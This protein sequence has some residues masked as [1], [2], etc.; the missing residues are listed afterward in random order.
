MSDNNHTI[1]V[2][3]LLVPVKGSHAEISTPHVVLF[4]DPGT[5][6]LYAMSLSKNGKPTELKYYATLESL[7]N[8]E[9]IK[10][11]FK[12]PDYMSKPEFYVSKK[13]LEKRDKKF[14]VIQPILNEL[15]SFLVSNNY[16]KG[17]IGKCLLIAEEQEIKAKRTQIY[18]WLY[19]Y[20]RAGCKINGFLRKPGTGKGTDKNY[21][22]KTGPK[23]GDGKKPNGRMRDEKDNKHIRAILNKHV[24]CSAP[25]SIPWAFQEYK[26][27]YASYPIYDSFT[28]DFEGYEPW[29]EEERITIFQFKTYAREHMA[30]KAEE[31]RESQGKTDE[32][33]KNRKGL[34]GTIENYYGQAPGKDYQIDETPLNIELVDEFDPKREKRLGRPTCY[35]V[36]DMFSRAWV[37]LLLTF[38]KS[39]V[40]TAREVLFI[41]FR[42]KQKFCD[43]IGVK[44]NEPW[45]FEK[46]CRNIIVDNLEFQAELARSFSKD[47]QIDVIFNTEGNSQQKGLVERRHLSLEDFLYSRAPGVG[48][49]EIASYVK[50]NLRKNALLNIRELYQILIDFIT[51]YNNYYPLKNMPLSE[52]M[53]K[54]GVKNT[55]LSKWNWGLINRAGS[56]R[57]VDDHELYLELLEAGQVTV[58][59][60]HLLLPGKYIRVNLNRKGS[61][62]LKYLC[63]WVYKNGYQESKKDGRGLP[64][65]PCK[66]MRYSM[67][68]I[69]IVTPDGLQEAT[70]H[71]EDEAYKHHSAEFIQYDKN[72]QTIEN[73]DQLDI[74]HKEQGKTR[75]SFKNVVKNARDEQNPINANQANTQ[76]LSEN[77]RT[78]IEHEVSNSQQEF[79]RIT[80]PSNVQ[81]NTPDTGSHSADNTNTAQTSTANLFAAKSKNNRSRRGKS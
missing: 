77:R 48:R 5:D 55:P 32:Y 68:K 4:I 23:R 71:P 35:S 3:D 50:R 53:R 56:L 11:F 39:S 60:D 18:D 6:R 16:G 9:I 41:A 52:E 29:P 74:Y 10:G 78:V 64:T 81:E 36:I 21:K 42:N 66:F 69:Y 30:G 37:G 67:G 47:A 13:Q 72:N 61:V 51:R 38:A 24:K 8:N 75:H 65:F 79:S 43:E 17:L 49:K 26:D 28:G 46:K 27:K 45:S 20:F 40:H 58:Y 22:N 14:T 25:K 44:L 54:D 70:L 80:G 31:F 19:R 1:L 76:D 34:T 15:E 59:R 73:S 63:P 33:N 2:S 7:K 62:G 12:K 57:N